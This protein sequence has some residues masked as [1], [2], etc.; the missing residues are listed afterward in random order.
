[1]SRLTQDGKTYII[2]EIG[3]NHNGD[4]AIAE[5]LIRAADFAGV[6]AVKFQKRT[7]RISTPRPEWDRLRDTPWGTMTYLEYRERIELDVE[8]Y[9][10]LVGLAHGLNLDLIV[11][12]WDLIA[13]EEMQMGGDTYFRPTAL[14]I[15]SAMLTNY[16]LVEETAAVE[17]PIILSTGMSTTSEIDQAVSAIASISSIYKMDREMT[18]MHCTSTYPCKPEELNL[19]AIPVLASKYPRFTIGYSGHEVGLAATVAAVALGAKVVER[20]ITL[21][22]SMWGTDQAASVEPVGF[23]KLVKDIRLVEQ[24]MGDGVKRVYAS[25][26]EALRKLRGVG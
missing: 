1:M 17:G 15:P 14:K 7:P 26:R 16:K 19:N 25:E 18:L 5:R 2:A 6:D 10:R 12:V 11:S 24:A 20:H 8:V 13:L 22:R 23:A 21:D 9:K 4:M 3:I